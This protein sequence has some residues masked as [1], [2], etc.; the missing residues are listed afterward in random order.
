MTNLLVLKDQEL[1]ARRNAC[2]FPDPGGPRHT[3]E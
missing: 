3:D 1:Q 2:F